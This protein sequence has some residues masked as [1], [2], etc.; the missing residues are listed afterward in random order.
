MQ[1]GGP[2]LLAAPTPLVIIV[3]GRSRYHADFSQFFPGSHEEDDL[4][5]ARRFSAAALNS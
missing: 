5:F 3:F 1:P 4:A 2:A